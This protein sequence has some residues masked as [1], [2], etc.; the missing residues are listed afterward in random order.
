MSDPYAGIGVADPY[1]GIG[2][3]VTDPDLLRQLNA[4]P[5]E[6]T[7]PALLRQLNATS[8]AP[9]A[10]MDLSQF[11]DSDLQ[12][13]AAGDLTKVSDSGLQML[14]RAAS[15]AIPRTPVG[16]LVPNSDLPTNI[17]AADDLP[18][19]AITGAQTP[20]NPNYPV[21]NELR[22]FGA[23]VWTGMGSFWPTIGQRIRQ[24]YNSVTGGPSMDAEIAEKRQLD[25]PLM[26]TAGGKVGAALPYAG[27]ALLPG[28]NTY[29]G[30]AAYGGMAG[31]AQPTLSNESTV[32]NTAIGAGLGLTGQKVG[33][34]LGNWLT[35]R[36]AEPFM[37]WNP[38]TANK[39]A[40]QSV[41]SDAPALNQTALGSTMN[42][43]NRIFGEARSPNVSNQLGAP[44]AQALS[45]AA[46]GLNSSSL[47]MFQ[48][49]GSVQDLMS[50]M[51]NGTATSAQLGDI[52]S[53][54]GADANQQM[55]TQ[56]GDRAAGRALFKL[57]DHVDDVIG[58]SI[59]DPDLAN[60]YQEVRGQYRNYGNITANSG[61]LNSATG[62]V[63]MTKL[64]SRLQRVDKPGYLRGGN[65]SDL[66][67]AARWGQ[68]TGEGAGPPSMLE[69]FGLPW[70]GYRAVNNPVSNAI[71]GVVSYVGAPI[72][73]AFPVG[74]QGLAFGATPLATQQ[75]R[76][77]FE[78]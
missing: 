21:G 75:V 73:P 54:L 24:G 27:M 53:N 34:I 45:D 70:L 61:I 19:A 39:V 13:L 52:S 29:A 23:N 26:S 74:L 1:E 62:D 59:I 37:G 3:E 16:S 25:A 77:F 58:N 38:S 41:G 8:Q 28:A 7:D 36:A 4:N 51:R 78:Q 17:V 44:T 71:G 6:V 57:K 5:R 40:A 63:N 64:A 66:Y 55:T 11:S 20:G 2:V 33:S 32:A 56:M 69:K 46:T 10:K 31:A 65:Q 42:R 35:T 43:F 15:A 48:G 30:A 67:N 72:A 47:G 76:D 49:N 12:A 50:L 60:E 14:H 68:A 18:S 22:D 9:A